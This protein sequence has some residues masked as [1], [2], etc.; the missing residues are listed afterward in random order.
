MDAR[1]VLGVD[2]QPTSRIEAD[3]LQS[4]LDEASLTT[5]RLSREADIF[6]SSIP[7]LLASSKT[8]WLGS[9]TYRT[10]L[11]SF[12]IQP[13]P[14]EPGGLAWMVTYRA[15]GRNLEPLFESMRS[16][17]L[18]GVQTHTR[19]RGYV[20]TATLIPRLLSRLGARFT[21]PNSEK[22]LIWELTDN[23]KLRGE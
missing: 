1:P 3:W 14:V 15:L 18:A 17:L 20:R 8:A 5:D 12:D 9:K 6:Q 16:E 19:L 4:Q 7:D 21:L 11:A 13:D 10:P 23:Y 2:V 22:F